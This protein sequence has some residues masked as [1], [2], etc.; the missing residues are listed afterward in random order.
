[1]ARFQNRELKK[2]LG[3]HFLH[4]DAICEKMASLIH[5]G[6]EDRL[7]EIGPGAGAL[8]RVIE[9]LPHQCLLLLEKDEYWARERQRMAGKKT[10]CILQ[11]AMTFDFT[12]LGP[13]PWT[14]LGNLPYNVASPLIWDIVSGARLCEAL[15]MVQKEVGE[16]LCAGPGNKT[17]GALSVW[18]QSFVVPGLA[19]TVGRGAFTPPPK[20]ESAVVHMMPR[21]DPPDPSLRTPLRLLLALS[22]QKRRKQ[23]G[24]I[25]EKA[26]LPNVKVVL[27]K[28]GL[29]PQVRPEGVSVQKFLLLAGFFSDVLTETFLLGYTK[30][31][32][33]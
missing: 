31:P 9:T 17:Y 20:V 23:L 15:F 12:R 7:L 22:F 24:G 33:A 2:S 4:N 5:P 32:S 30:P 18:V 3:Q 11:D 6:E 29:S 27:E 16:R 26:G 28:A 1:M 10:H 14:V 19:F 8:T 13:E 21:N 25:L